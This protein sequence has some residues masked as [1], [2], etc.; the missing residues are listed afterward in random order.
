MNITDEFMDYLFIIREGE[1]TGEIKI[2]QPVT[3]FD[4]AVMFALGKLTER[5]IM[6][7]TQEDLGREMQSQ[8][9]EG[10]WQCTG[11]KANQLSRTLGFKTKEEQ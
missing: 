3:D 4:L 10:I 5:G 2:S 9:G 7:M 11:V 8:C 6:K 1:R